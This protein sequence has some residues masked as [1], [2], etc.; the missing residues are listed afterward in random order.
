MDTKLQ[1]CEAYA[2]GFYVTPCYLPF[3][4]LPIMFQIIF[5]GT[6]VALALLFL[7]CRGGKKGDSERSSEA[8]IERLSEDL[9]RKD[10]DRMSK[11]PD[12]DVPHR[13]ASL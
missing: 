13:S 9:A 8:T 12:E 5:F 10:P 1:N 2:P 6:L 4:S 7:S 11:L 3:T